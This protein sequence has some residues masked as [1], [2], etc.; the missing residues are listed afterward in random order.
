[1][2]GS[3]IRPLPFVLFINEMA[4]LFNDGDRYCQ[5]SIRRRP[6]LH[7]NFET[8]VYL[9]HASLTSMIGQTN[10]SYIYININAMAYTL[11]VYWL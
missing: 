2:Q 5:L 10:D 11:L 9:V 8:D 1:M 6:Q 7:S 3:A 4:N